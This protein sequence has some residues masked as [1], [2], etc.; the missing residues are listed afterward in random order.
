MKLSGQILANIDPEIFRQLREITPQVAK[1]DVNVWVNDSETANRLNWIDL[2]T[3][4]RDLLPELDA[5]SAWARSNGLTQ[6][7]LCGMGGSSLA[8]EVIASTYKKSLTTLDSTDPG[9]ILNSIPSDLSKAV[10]V[11]GS[12]SGTTIETL[13][14]FE[15]YVN[16]FKEADLN[17][18]QH[19]VIIT[20]LGT[21]LDIRAGT[22]PNADS[23]LKRPPTF[24]SAL[25]TL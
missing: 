8:P 2:P 3:K 14:Q 11:V 23:A 15:F 25:T 12:K 16:I 7:V 10:V 17:P 5:L 9:Q 20:D 18:I 22:K 19:M 24:G 21:P 1:K 4:S 13:T 6:I